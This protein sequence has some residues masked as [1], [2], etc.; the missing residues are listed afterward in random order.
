MNTL[1]QSRPQQWTSDEIA[2]LKL[3]FAE[4]KR[5]KAIA[6]EIGRSETAV[7]K[8]LTRS[9]IRKKYKRN[10]RSYQTCKRKKILK[11]SK[12]IFRRACDACEQQSDTTEVIA[13]LKAKGYTIFKQSI[14]NSDD[15]DTHSYVLDGKPASEMKL[16]LVANRMRVDERLPIFFVQRLIW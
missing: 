2:K 15:K 9:G 3:K 7:N 16:L 14:E 10:S 8:F 11:I 1:S 4:G 12:N 6:N 5:L 13:Y